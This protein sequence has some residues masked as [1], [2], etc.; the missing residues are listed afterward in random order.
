MDEWQIRG[1]LL[2]EYKE[3]LRSYLAI[4]SKSINKNKNKEL[5]KLC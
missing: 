4:L 2:E 3:Y 5:R 1:W